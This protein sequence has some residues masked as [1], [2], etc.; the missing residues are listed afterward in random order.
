MVA[1]EAAAVAE[2][3]ALVAEVAAAVA[4]EAA[5][6]SEVSRNP[7]VTASEEAVGVP[8]F[9]ILTLPAS[10][11]LELFLPNSLT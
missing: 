4:D 6:F 2:L 10:K 9:V 8:T 7:F 1:D 5:L 11:M 3:A